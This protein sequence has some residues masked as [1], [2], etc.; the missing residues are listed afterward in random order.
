MILSNNK[1]SNGDKF[2]KQLH[3]TSQALIV[4]Q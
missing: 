2:P 3:S 1:T 4:Y